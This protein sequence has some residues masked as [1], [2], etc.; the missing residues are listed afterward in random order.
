MKRGT[1]DRPL[2]VTV[3]ARAGDG[4]DVTVS[5]VEAQSLCVGSVLCSPGWP[6]PQVTVFEARIVVLQP[7][8]PILHGQQVCM[9][10]CSSRSNSVDT[11]VDH[12]AHVD[13]DSVRSTTIHSSLTLTLTNFHQYK[14]AWLLLYQVVSRMSSSSCCSGMQ[15][16]VHAHCAREE[17]SISALVALLDPSTGEVA[18]AKPRCLVAGQSARLQVRVARP[19]SLECYADCRPLGRVALRD[20]GHTLAVGIVT[21]LLEFS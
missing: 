19:L 16:T 12:D 8:I 15:V 21:Q 4:V 3:Q 11:H 14:Y 10:S 18:R 9:H 2:C 13:Y 6:V 17:G 20:A 7:P 5:G 1:F